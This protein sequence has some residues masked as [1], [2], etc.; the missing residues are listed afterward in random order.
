VIV[1]AGLDLAPACTA[2]RQPMTPSASCVMNPHKEDKT[3][4]DG[5]ADNPFPDEAAVMVRHPAP[6]TTAPGPSS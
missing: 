6:G 3:V 2:C 5:Q 1:P 4:N